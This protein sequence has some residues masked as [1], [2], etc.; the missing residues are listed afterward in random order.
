MAN[1]GWD[2][3]YG[4]QADG[5]TVVATTIPENLRLLLTRFAGT[6]PPP[7]PTQYQ[8]W[9]DTTN[10]ILK[11]WDGAAWV[12]VGARQLLRPLATARLSTSATLTIPL[13]IARPRFTVT[14][15]KLYHLT[16]TTSD[17][18]NYWTVD[19]RRDS[20]SAS[21][22]A[23]PPVTNAND[24]VAKTTKVYA[25]DQNLLVTSAGASLVLTK[26]GSATA[27]VDL[28]VTLEG[29]EANP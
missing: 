28:L 11:E 10:G 7:N 6:A 22:F 19:L 9:L 2:I 23:T 16:A 14:A 12:E 27:L 21:M 8:W 24:L 15:L 26:T 1:D 17:G 29:Y 3:S 4:D 13:A 20:D 25:P 5:A 18:S